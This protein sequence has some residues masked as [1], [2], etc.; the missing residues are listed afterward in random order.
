MKSKRLNRQV[1]HHPHAASDRRGAAHALIASMLVAFGITIAFSI[2]YAYMQLIRTELRTATDAAAKAGAE[3]LARTRDPDQ[4]VAAAVQFAS[5]NKVGGRDFQIRPNDVVLGQAVAGQNGQWNFNAGMSPYNAVQVQSK[6]GGSGI[7]SQVEL[8]FKTLTGRDGFSTS[9]KATAGRQEIEICLC[10]DR[11]QSMI[12]RSDS[13]AYPSGNP[14]LYPRSYY[15]STAIQNDHSPPHPSL[16]RW[17]AL[18]DAINVF[19]D[20]AG[21]AQSP[22]R[23]S[24]V[25]WSSAARQ[26]YFPRLSSTDVSCDIP[27]P[28][29]STFTWSSNRTAVADR[30]TSLSS[31]PLIGNT[32]LSDG[33]DEAV[34]VLTGSNSLVQSN[35]V[36]ILFTDGVWA[37]CRHPEDAARDAASAGVAIHCVSMLTG[38]QTVL[39]NIASITGGSYNEATNAEQ[40]RTTFRNLARTVSIVL[41]E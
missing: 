21:A 29:A 34:R 1:C 15:P 37:N 19:L 14:L 16:S 24:L 39:R 17:A 22:P 38:S 41:T 4:A 8:F 31:G 32:K 33:I 9:A 5:L 20:E 40:L 30:M 36:I 23:T 26:S 27:L 18:R 12:L 28:N 6:V 7:F 11:S 10:L 25:T 35:K 2:D 3:N 13:N